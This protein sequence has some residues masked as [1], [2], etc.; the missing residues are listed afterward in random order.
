MPFALAR[1]PGGLV[2]SLGLLTAVG[3]GA[4]LFTGNLLLAQAS[5]ARPGD[6][7]LVRGLLCK[8]LVCL[9]VL[10]EPGSAAGRAASAV[11]GIAA[12][13]AAVMAGNLPGGSV[14]VAGVYGVVYRRAASG[15]SSGAVRRR[16]PNREPA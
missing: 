4:E 3:A 16:L 15:R 8:V 14:A 6:V 1:L 7:A 10:L 5:A 12:N 9:A 2:F 13:L 11:P